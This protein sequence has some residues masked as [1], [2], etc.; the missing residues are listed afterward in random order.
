V[1]F[2][3]EDKAARAL[4]GI[5]PSGIRKYFDLLS[6]MEDV[7][8]LGVGEPDFPVPWH[9]TETAI[10]SLSKG[11]TSYTSNSGLLE[12]RQVISEWLEG[13]YGLHYEA[14]DEIL[15]TVGVSEGL[16]LSLRA[17]VNPGD[18]VIMADPCYVSYM[19]CTILAGGIPV[20]VPTRR[21][22]GFK[23]NPLALEKAITPR[24][25]I[26]LLNYPSNPTGATMSRAELIPIAQIVEAHDLVVVSDEIYERLTYGETHC[27]FASLPG[28][29]ER[30]ILLN[31][32]SKAYAMT[33]MR[34]GYA[35]S[36]K[37]FIGLMTKIHQ[38]TALC[39][40]TTSQ[41]GAI[42]GLRNGSASVTR[43]VKE[44]D[45]RRRF[46]VDGLNKIGLECSL[47]EG[48]FY[49]FPS[50]RVTG[51]TSEEFCDR[52]LAEKK[53]AAVPG[54]AFGESGEGHIR[55]AYAN[56][57]PNLKKALDRMGEFVKGLG[58]CR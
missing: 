51:L 8:T 44:Y 37:T 48:A 3:P 17:L 41:M 11:Y 10:Y 9:I 22:E 25:K 1:T 43:M 56:A 26:L 50:I 55:C 39:A 5:T 21:E 12:L 18:E 34:V 54:S 45:Q 24:S 6:E 52:L 15:I 23:L 46:F 38:Y 27:P 29:K 36:N 7:I 28:M 31:G 2:S 33:G 20:M 57:M 49:A 35:A 47:P 53:V 30:T 42:E 16:D 14:E 4:L 40:P 58:V 13:L 19:P 32:F